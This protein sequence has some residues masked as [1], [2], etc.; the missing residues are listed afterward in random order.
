MIKPNF[1]D[2]FPIRE[3]DVYVHYMSFRVIIGTNNGRL[4]GQFI[5]TVPNEETPGY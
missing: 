3:V 1:G 5:L 2:N 4:C